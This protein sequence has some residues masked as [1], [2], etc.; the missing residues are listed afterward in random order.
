MNRTQD[1]A[2]ARRRRT[3][4]LAED[5]KAAEKDLEFSERRI[6]IAQAGLKRAEERLAALVKLQEKQEAEADGE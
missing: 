5:I 1:N 6:E 3:R 4:D 2:N